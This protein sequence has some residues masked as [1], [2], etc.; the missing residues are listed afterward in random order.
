MSYQ[1]KPLRWHTAASFMFS[2]AKK[3][4]WRQLNCATASPS[5][6]HRAFTRSMPGPSWTTALLRAAAEA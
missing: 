5:P 4:S 2:Q 3:L 1:T 6:A